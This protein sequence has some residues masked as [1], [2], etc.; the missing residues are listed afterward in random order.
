ML[1]AVAPMTHLICECTHLV[2]DELR[3]VENLAPAL[4]ENN[5]VE[6]HAEDSIDISRATE[7]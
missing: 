5:D 1:K 3:Q 7:L 6:D 4:R 2:E